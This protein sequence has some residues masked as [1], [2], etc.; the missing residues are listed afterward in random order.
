MILPWA[1]IAHLTV[2]R[3]AFRDLGM[4][5]PQRHRQH[6]P[7]ETTAQMAAL[8]G[9]PKLVLGQTPGTLAVH[10]KPLLGWVKATT[11]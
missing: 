7:D 5:Q 10:I 3:P 1:H 2:P 9:N 6:Y 11:P 4:W 8:T